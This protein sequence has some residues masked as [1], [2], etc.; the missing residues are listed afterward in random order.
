MKKTVISIVAQFSLPDTWTP[1]DRRRDNQRMAGAQRRHPPRRYGD[2][3]AR[4][5]NVGFTCRAFL[6]QLLLYSNQT[7]R[8]SPRTLRA[9]PGQLQTGLA[10]VVGNYFSFYF[11]TGVQ[12]FRLPLFYSN[13]AGCDF[14]PNT[15][16]LSFFSNSRPF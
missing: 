11:P 2:G 3:F 5:H 6:L 13:V 15:I 8:I 14:I 12:P 9:K 1:P 16:S 10:G 4:R 7:L